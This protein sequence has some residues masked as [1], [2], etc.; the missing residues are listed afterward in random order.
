ML[1]DYLP[2][3]EVAKATKVNYH[4]LLA[5]IR[6]NKIKAERLGGVYFVH[7]DEVDKIEPP[8]PSTSRAR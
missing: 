5:R 3:A 4:T 2:V 6:A 8:T 1:T 7:K